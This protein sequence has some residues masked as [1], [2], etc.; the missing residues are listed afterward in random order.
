MFFKLPTQCDWISAF[1]YI[2]KIESLREDVVKG[3]RF[4]KNGSQLGKRTS[5]FIDF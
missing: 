5:V 2:V 1:T 3:Q 4:L